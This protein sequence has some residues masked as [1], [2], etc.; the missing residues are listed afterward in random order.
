MWYSH[1]V[2]DAAFIGRSA[3]ATPLWWPSDWREEEEKRRQGIRSR[4]KRLN[5]KESY[6]P[7]PRLYFT[8]AAVLCCDAPATKRDR[9]PTGAHTRMRLTEAGW[10]E[11]RG[12]ERGVSVQQ[13]IKTYL[14]A[15][16]TAAFTGPSLP[17]CHGG[18]LV[19]G[20]RSVGAA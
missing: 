3:T 2:M 14:S 8:P 17:S 1:A 5:K 19:G 20:R 10:S 7:S 18:R 4:D 6:H 9:S 12:R 13:T 15:E 11:G 16:P